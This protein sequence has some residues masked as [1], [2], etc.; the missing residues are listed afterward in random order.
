MKKLFA[1]LLFLF[2]IY[3][4]LQ[5]V[6]FFFGPGHSV[7]YKINDFEVK[8][9][10]IN[11]SKN[12][13][14][15]YNFIVNNNE[16][17]FYFQIFNNF[18][19]EEK[20]ITDI[21]SYK[22][23]ENICILPIFKEKLVLTDLMCL[24]NDIVYNY[25][26]LKNSDFKIDEFYNSL[27]LHLPDENLNNQDH[28]GE[29]IL[30]KNNM[31][32][33]YYL[34]FATYKGFV[35]ANSTNRVLNYQSIFNKDV[36]NNYL[37]IYINEYYVTVN[38][39]E[40]YGFSKI[41]IYN[42][43]TGKKEEI[44]L[45]KNI[46]KNSYIQGIFDDSVY[47]FDRSN[48]TQYEINT[49]TKNVLEVGNVNTGVKVYKN[50]TFER[51]S[52]YECSNEDILFEAKGENNGEYYFLLKNGGKETGYT[53]YYQKENEAYKIYRVNNTNKN[54]YTYL[55]QTQNV[56]KIIVINEYIYF[57]DDNYLKY[58]SD[59]TGI[60]TLLYN[61]ELYFNQNIKYQIIY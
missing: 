61:K 58:Y 25:A 44:V 19:N 54:Q 32:P 53:Y 1:T 7:T 38:Y 48:K 11:E 5:A 17:S 22:D 35:Y 18:D 33:N 6:F 15:S 55:F 24:K 26:E 43:K 42:I 60:R 8:E 36:Y 29:I 23:D 20:I 30:Y 16:K 14:K 10:Y 56:N 4:L 12:E 31:Q 49:K 47:I 2:L 28:K 9:K 37:S 39:D 57:I 13:I 59:K 27:D 40:E 41:Y 45:A 3:F 21:K 51:L 34:S 50:G 46:E 52:A